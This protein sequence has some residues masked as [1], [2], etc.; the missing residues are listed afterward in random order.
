MSKCP[1]KKLIIVF[2]KLNTAGVI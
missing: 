2:T 1:T